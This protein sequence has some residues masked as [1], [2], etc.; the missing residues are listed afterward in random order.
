[1]TVAERD[2]L[3]ASPQDD[4]GCIGYAAQ[5]SRNRGIRHLLAFASTADVARHGCNREFSSYEALT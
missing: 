4:A 3:I 2:D 1:V 5:H